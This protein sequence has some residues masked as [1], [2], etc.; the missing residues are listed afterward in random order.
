MSKGFL[1]EYVSQLRIFNWNEEFL[2][3]SV[4]YLIHNADGHYDLFQNLEVDKYWVRVLVYPS[5]KYL[6]LILN[7]LIIILVIKDLHDLLV[8]CLRLYLPIEDLQYNFSC[9]RFDEKHYSFKWLVDLDYFTLF[10]CCYVYCFL[11]LKAD[12]F[13]LLNL[14]CLRIFI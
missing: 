13:C 6:C 12:H 1:N 7:A 4:T 14:M 5:F 10:K 9:D 8:K 2:F 3:P 11:Q